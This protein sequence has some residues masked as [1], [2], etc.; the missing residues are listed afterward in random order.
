MLQFVVTFNLTLFILFTLFYLYQIGYAVVGVVRRPQKPPEAKKNHRYAVLIAARNES[1]VIAELIDSIKKQNYPRELLDIF[2]V[3]DNCTDNTA[4]V[5]RYAGATAVYERF[6]H[7]QVGKGYA[8]DFVLKS[9][10]RDFG[11]NTYEGYFVF[12]ADN[13]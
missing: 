13:L 4:D 10:A 12:D 6:N 9:I 1:A 5:A 11:A 7:L 2:V 8:L 3:A